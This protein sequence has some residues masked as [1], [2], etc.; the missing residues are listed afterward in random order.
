V[1]R[2]SDEAIRA[3][4]ETGDFS[5]PEA[6][7]YLAETLIRRRDK[8]VDYYLKQINPLDDFRIID[9]RFQF[10]NLGEKAGLASGSTYDFWWFRFDN[11]SSELAGLGG[12]EIARQTS[13]PLPEERSE[14]L[15]VRIRTR[16]ASVPGW[17]KNIDVY[18]RNTSGHLSVVG[19][20]REIGPVATERPIEA[21]APVLTS[22]VEY[23]GTFNGLDTNQRNLVKD[24][25]RR[26]NEAT[27][28]ELDPETS[29]NSAPA[30]IRRTFESITHAL[31]RTLLTDMS[32][33]SLGTALDLIEQVD[34]VRGKASG[35]DPPFRIIVRLRRDAR[36][37]LG[38]S[39]EFS[40]EADNAIYHRGYP[41]SY[42][43]QSG[44]PSIHFSIA[45]DG[46]RANIGVDYRPSGYPEAL[47]RGRIPSD[48]SDVG[49]GDN[50]TRH[51]E[52]WQGLTDWW[53]NV[54]GVPLGPHHV[55]TE[56]PD[57]EA[58]PT[59]PRLPRKGRGSIEEAVFDFLESWLIEDRPDH[60]LA[61]LSSRAFT[62][63]QSEGEGKRGMAPYIM[64]ERMEKAGER[65]GKAKRLGDVSIGIQ[66]SNPEFRIVAQPHHAQFVLYEIPE[67]IALSRDCAGRSLADTS[68]T[69]I[70]GNSGKHFGVLFYLRGA[71]FVGE[72]VMLLW[73]K[74][75]SYWKIVSYEVEP[76]PTEM[77]FPIVYRGDD[78]TIDRVEGD[79]GFIEQNNEFLTAWLLEDRFDEAMGIFSPRCFSC[80]NLYPREDRSQ[81][82][83]DQDAA[84]I[85]RRGLEQI[86]RGVN[87]SR[88]ADSIEGVDP[89][90]RDIRIIGHQ[91]E[92]A[93]TLLS[94]PDHIAGAFD[95]SRFGTQ[96]ED[97]DSG[98][99]GNHYATAFRFRARSGAPAALLLIWGKEEGEWRIIACHVVT[100]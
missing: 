53:L 87:K 34:L 2:F 74:E 43:Q 11:D 69:E 52:R 82:R 38:Q 55:R 68:G 30:S 75:G 28:Q 24:W 73:A 29:F 27:E 18:L 33:N 85:L 79:P 96:A 76:E 99:Y 40:R 56:V 25:F 51:L 83:S 98:T 65:I 26:Y 89:T 93:Y 5:D 31:S 72:P 37:I 7:R 12:R 9:S 36:E 32:G 67:D 77:P 57:P 20:E 81:T 62:C 60:A 91:R 22:A 86:A 21:G 23:G 15:M 80:V 100:P 71:G 44:G 61:Y 17:L 48:N 54:F 92:D 13:I 16:S 1:S 35:E 64:L 50:Y 88:L 41:L 19:V 84:G 49:S 90:H 6:E 59:I 45:L 58:M 39:R 3:I 78:F 10:S 47:M 97:P 70:S 63:L 66:L 4:V 14:Y 94:M 42:R 8:I 95:C 46:G